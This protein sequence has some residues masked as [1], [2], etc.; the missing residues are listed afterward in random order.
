[1]AKYI[2]VGFIVLILV[3]LLSMI[4][5]DD[6]ENGIRRIK[7][8]LNFIFIIPI[9]MAM[10]S[11]RTNLIKT[12]LIGACIGGFV[13]LAITDYQVNHIGMGR[14][15]GFYNAIMFGSIAAFTVLASFVSLLFIKRKKIHLTLITL[16]LFSTLYAAILSGTRGAWIGLIAGVLL[17]LCLS[18]IMGKISKKRIVLI[19]L[20]GILMASIA[21]KLGRDKIVSRWSDTVQDI[22]LNLADRDK[23]TRIG[24]RLTM[25]DAAVNIWHRHPI[26]G[27]GIGDF[28]MDYWEMIGSGKEGFAD[29]VKISHSYAHSTFFDALAGTGIFGFVGL[30]VSTFILPA[31]FFLKAF[32]ASKNEYDRYTSVFGQVFVAAFMIFGLTENWLAPS[33]LVMTFSLLL[34]IMASRFGSATR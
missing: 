30:I 12:F 31:V 34:A 16:S 20:S 29:E 24:L 13:L 9:F 25:W 18:F 11:V 23:N 33:Q 2:L 27:T 3:S 28:Q 5:A 6:V 32:K 8:L 22:K 4:N 17:A 26:I 1:M 19:L 7:K 10:V 15:P 21:G 14:T